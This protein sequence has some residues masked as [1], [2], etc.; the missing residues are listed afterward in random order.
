VVPG[1]TSFPY[2]NNCHSSRTRPASQQ[3]EDTG[4]EGDFSFFFNH[5]DGKLGSQPSRHHTRDRMPFRLNPTRRISWF[6]YSP[7]STI[8]HVTQPSEKAL[9][10]HSPNIPPHSWADRTG[11]IVIV[12]ATSCHKFVERGV[13]D[14]VKGYVVHVAE[15][16]GIV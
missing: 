3:A 9:S 15:G 6:S 14:V 7:S 10:D 1:S 13:Q 2:V 12:T 8:A 4:L 16:D 11:F 5:R